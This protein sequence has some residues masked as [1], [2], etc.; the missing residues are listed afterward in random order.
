MLF[1]CDTPHVMVLVWSRY[2]RLVYISEW[3]LLIME[4][5]ATK[6]SKAD[7][8]MVGD[9]QGLILTWSCSE[10]KK[11]T[12][13]MMFVPLLACIVDGHVGLP[14][15]SKL[16]DNIARQ[17]ALLFHVST[18]PLGL[19]GYA[20][21]RPSIMTILAKASGFAELVKGLSMHQL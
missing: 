15:L 21:R 17:R 3:D 6:Q 13:S 19:S 9:V 2:W 5:G 7:K 20:S 10:Q 12:K 1:N 14:F 4:S 8:L 16:I 18:I 11:A